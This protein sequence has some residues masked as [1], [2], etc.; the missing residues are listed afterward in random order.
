MKIGCSFLAVLVFFVSCQEDQKQ[1]VSPSKLSSIEVSDYFYPKDSISPFVI[2]FKDEQAPL[3]ER[4]FR[5]I[6]MEHADSNL[7]ILEK[8]N[9]SLRITEGFTFLVDEGFKVIDHMMVDGN[10]KKRMSRLHETS[11]F[12]SE[13][14]DPVL[15]HVDF[16]SPLDSVIISMRS[17]REITHHLDH[18]S[19]EENEGPAIV[20]R[21]SSVVRFINIYNQQQSSRLVVTDNYYAK[22]IGLVRFSTLDEKVNYEVVRFFSDKWWMEYA[23]EN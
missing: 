9:A 7:F 12:P 8:Y 14:N 17:K 6:V 21:D 23:V 10:G 4:F 13:M 20:L 18:F 1:T 19:F 16:P 15:F 5:S 2:A 11:Y 22:G 3:D